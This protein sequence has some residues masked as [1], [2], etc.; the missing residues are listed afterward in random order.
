MALSRSERGSGWGSGV[1]RG[2]LSAEAPRSSAPGE[3]GRGRSS[4]GGGGGGEGGAGGAGGA[5]GAGSCSDDI[6]PARTYDS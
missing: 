6:I 3:G 4:A 2:G 1:G 5:H